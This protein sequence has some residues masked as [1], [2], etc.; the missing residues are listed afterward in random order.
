M[1][2]SNGNNERKFVSRR[3]LDALFIFQLFLNVIALT[4]LLS[5]SYLAYDTV[6]QINERQ[7]EQVQSQNDTQICAQHDL[8]LAI[9]RVGADLN[10]PAVRDIRPPSIEGINCEALRS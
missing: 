9:R 4:I 10:L 2:L 5:V 3:M 8:I 7:I 6:G 1:T